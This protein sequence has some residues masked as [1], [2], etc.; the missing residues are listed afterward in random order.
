MTLT[1]AMTTLVDR[2]ADHMTAV[3][4]SRA[5]LGVLS[6][7]SHDQGKRVMDALDAR[8]IAEVA[9]CRHV[10]WAQAITRL[11]RHEEGAASYP[12]LA[13]ILDPK[14]QKMRL[15]D[16]AKASPAALAGLSEKEARLLAE[17]IGV[18]SIEELATNTFI[19][20]AQVIAHLATFEKI[21]GLRQAA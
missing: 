8:T 18:R 20:K 21:E 7:L 1:T 9:T 15:R 19:L 16:L 4:L 6:G 2:D 13:A 10:A 5:P 17:A 12:G 11:A 3:D 14:W